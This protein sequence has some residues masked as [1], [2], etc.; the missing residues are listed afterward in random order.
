MKKPILGDKT[1]MKRYGDLLADIKTCIR[2]AQNRA[3][4]SANAKMI[5][6]YWDIGQMVAKRQELEGWGKGLLRLIQRIR[7]N[8]LKSQGK[9]K[10]C[11]GSLRNYPGPIMSSSSRNSK[12]CPPVYGMPARRLPRGGVAT[13]YPS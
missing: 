7:Y 13:H 10:L 4:M 2:Q 6:M 11:N 1:V 3:V 8:R 9:P 5:R 12:I